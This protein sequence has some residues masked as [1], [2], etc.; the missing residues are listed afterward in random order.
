[1]SI[2]AN[3]VPQPPPTAK[4]G[5]CRV[6]GNLVRIAR[7]LERVLGAINAEITTH[8]RAAI[9]TELETDP[10]VAGDDADL[11]TWYNA[12]KTFLEA[13]PLSKTIP[14]IKTV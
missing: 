11:T 8:T 4:D 12:A 10:G 2:P 9:K 5:A 14:A 7:D 6:R 3:P 13:A 1:M